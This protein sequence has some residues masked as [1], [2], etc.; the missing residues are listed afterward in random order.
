MKN[1]HL[2]F[3]FNAVAYKSNMCL[4]IYVAFYLDNRGL[5]LAKYMY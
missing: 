3:S 2:R 5:L 1:S 4:Y